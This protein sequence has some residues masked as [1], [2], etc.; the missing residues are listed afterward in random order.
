MFI[1]VWR[2]LGIFV[3]VVMLSSIVATNCI[4][5]LVMRNADYSK[6]H[7]WP[8]ALGAVIAAVAVWLI[9]RY[10]HSRPGEMVIEKNTVTAVERK[11]IH[12]L[13][14]IHFEYWAFLPLAFS[15]LGYFV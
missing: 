15:V 13:F 14:G 5:D 1:V 12:S 6:W 9:G 7:Y 11:K 10:L 8:K 3:P 4:V 2:G